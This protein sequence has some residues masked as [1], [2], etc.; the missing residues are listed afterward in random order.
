MTG[1]FGLAC[2]DGFRKR[3]SCEIVAGNAC[4]HGVERVVIAGQRYPGLLATGRRI[5]FDDADDVVFLRRTWAS[6][7]PA[8]KRRPNEPKDS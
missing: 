3:W 1:V 7:T 4:Q 5:D 6:I 2:G 8:R